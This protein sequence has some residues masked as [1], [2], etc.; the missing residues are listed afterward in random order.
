MLLHDVADPFLEGAKL[1]LYHG[2][3]ALANL[4]FVLF[5][6][7]FIIT[8]DFIYTKRVILFIF[9]WKEHFNYAKSDF[10][11]YLLSFLQLLHFVW[12]A[13]ILKMVWGLIV[14]HQTSD[15]IREKEE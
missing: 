4:L 11:F 9:Y 6:T 5:S 1:S 7:T 10:F 13:L 2:H 14:T 15:D 8:R 3:K 12:T